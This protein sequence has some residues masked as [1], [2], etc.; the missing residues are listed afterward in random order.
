[1]T[2]ESLEHQL[3]TADFAVIVFTPDDLTEDEKS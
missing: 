3:N 1:M 2:V